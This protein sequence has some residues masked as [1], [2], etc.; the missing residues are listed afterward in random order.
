M[1]TD[2]KTVYNVTACGPLAGSGSGGTGGSGP[3]SGDT[4]L[5]QVDSNGVAHSL[6]QVSTQ[7]LTYFEGSL[8]LT[9]SGGEKC[10]RTG[11]DRTVEINL[12]CDRSV[13]IG[14]PKYVQEDNC[15]Y[16]F[17]WPTALA[18]PPREL[19][20][21]AQGGKYDMRPLL[22]QRNWLVDAGKSGNVYK[23]GGCRALDIKA[24]PECSQQDGVG[25]CRYTMTKDGPANAKVLGYVTGE[26][27]E[28]GE[29]ELSL[30]YHNGDTCSEGRSSLVHV[31]FRCSPGKGAVS[32]GGE[33]EERW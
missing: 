10:R 22:Q 15:S 29:G 23:I 1:V 19:Q 3:C 24:A 7:Q 14:T 17:V 18:C 8:T 27:V 21:V 25:A 16:T 20:C 32:W 4:P 9:Y 31:H 30:T 13:Y 11:K 28:T 5:C 6:G 26:L 2:H 33:E 12:E